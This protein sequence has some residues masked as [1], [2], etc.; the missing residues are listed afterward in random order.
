MKPVY[1]PRAAID[2]ESIVVY[3]GEVLGSPQAAKRLYK[4]ITSAVANLCAM[5][6]MGRTFFSDAL[7]RKH[8]RS[9]LV[10]NYRI[11]Y[12]YDA[13]ILTVWRVVHTRQDLDDYA[14]IEWD[15]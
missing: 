1:R 7:D 10:E 6:E 4:A 8:Y 12:T 3:T 11:F 9:Y 2:I 13:E 15:D 14:L 5:P